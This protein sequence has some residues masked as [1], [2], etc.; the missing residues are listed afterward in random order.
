[1]F[2]AYIYARDGYT[3]ITC[4]KECHDGNRQPGH[5]FLSSKCGYA[6]RYH[7]WNVAVQCAFCNG[8]M[9]GDPIAFA[10]E[11]RKKFGVAEYEATERLYRAQLK[12]GGPKFKIDWQA[13]IDY[14][15]DPPI[16]HSLV[17]PFLTEI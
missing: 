12:V 6:L 5:L 1:V 15:E 17:L 2:R 7:P 14:F 13:A 3:C 16:A 4:G 8:P 9:N 10:R 11:A